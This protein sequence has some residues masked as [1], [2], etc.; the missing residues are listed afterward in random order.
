MSEAEHVKAN[1]GSWIGVYLIIA[2]FVLGTLALVLSSVPLWVATGV[3]LVAGGICALA[4]NI[5]EQAY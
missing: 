2:G 3:A 4:S 1:I 5:M